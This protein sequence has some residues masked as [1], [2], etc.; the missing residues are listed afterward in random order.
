MNRFFRTIRQRLLVDS[1]IGRYILY[2]IVEII[3]VVIGNLLPT[4][5]GE[6]LISIKSKYEQSEL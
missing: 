2:A 6:L 4:P 5:K 1:T 3:L